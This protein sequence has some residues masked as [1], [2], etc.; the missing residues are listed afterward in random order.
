M[1]RVNL[2][3]YGFVR[4]PEEDFSDDGNRFTCFKVGK[5]VKVSKLVADGQA[6]LSINSSSAGKGTLPFDVYKELPHFNDATWKYNGVSVSSLTDEDLKN[7][8]EACIA[9]EN[10]YEAAEASIQYP[11]LNEITDKATRITAKRMAELEVVEYWIKNHALEAAAKFSH[12]E[13]RQVQEYAK[14][15]MAD[16]KRFDPET[17]PQTIV[18]QQYSFTFV[19]PDY[20]T[21]ASYWFEYLK[22]LFSKYNL[23]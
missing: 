21:S 20:E 23:N 10:E 22:E 4:W 19:K 9:Y 6:Y 7:F 3:K 2:I 12:Y 5:N 13:W 18:G 17:Y 8:Y 1:T 11:T 14:N 16:V 15:L